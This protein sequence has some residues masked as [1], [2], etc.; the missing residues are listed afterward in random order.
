MARKFNSGAFS[1]IIRGCEY[2]VKFEASIT[3]LLRVSI[4]KG[5]AL[6][7]FR[8]SFYGTADAK[9]ARYILEQSLEHPK[10]A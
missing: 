9:S 3:R 2:T 4:Y 10:S 8:E 7:D 5:E 1:F 6:M